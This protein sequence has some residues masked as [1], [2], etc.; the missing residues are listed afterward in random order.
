[1]LPKAVS[2]EALPFHPDVEFYEGF[3][4]AEN[5]L[6]PTADM[7]R[8]GN[9]AWIQAN[10]AL[11]KP[12]WP[13]PF[14]CVVRDARMVGRLYL[15]IT[16]STEVILETTRTAGSVELLWPKVTRQTLRNFMIMLT[17]TPPSLGEGFWAPLFHASQDIYFDWF[18]DVL[19]AVEAVRV[20]ESRTGCRVK[21]IVSRPLWHWQRET[22]ALLDVSDE[23]IVCWNGTCMRVPRLVVTSVRT[24]GW[25]SLP[26]IAG[27]RWIR[28][29]MIRNAGEGEPTPPYI[30]ISRSGR[31]RIENEDE[32]VAFM[33]SRGIVPVRLEQ[34]SVA[35]QIQLFRGARLI[36]GAHGSGLTN[37]IFSDNAEVV[38]LFGQWKS[39]CFGALALGFGHG[40]TG[41][42]TMPTMG[43]QIRVNDVDLDFPV[44][45]ELVRP[46]I[47]A[48]L[49][50]VRET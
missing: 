11:W 3:G 46:V 1:M 27:L 34:M 49:K 40:Y 24:D 5:L 38:E 16:R 32:V 10:L 39:L 19:P 33:Q 47:D 42:D 12:T 18:I 17:T 44:D 45:V 7:I 15:G 25:T 8:P 31:R 28:D 43:F 9:A 50:K 30:Y 14:V 22:L 6:L 29:V 26:S 2:R 21:F 48:A 23:D 41:A 36:V 20:L 37:I 13:R 4:R 35:E